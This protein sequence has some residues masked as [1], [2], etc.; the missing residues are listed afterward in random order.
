MDCA[1][2]E[3]ENTEWIEPRVRAAPPL[4]PAVR[5][6]RAIGRGA[7]RWQLNADDPRLDVPLVHAR[8]RYAVPVTVR[9]RMTR[10]HPRTCHGNAQWWRA[11]IGTP[12]DRSPPS[13]RAHQ[14]R[15]WVSAPSC[16]APGMGTGLGRVGWP[17]PGRCSR[18]AERLCRVG[19][20]QEFCTATTGFAD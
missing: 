14:Q 17:S 9:V 15:R 6:D 18:G 10:W 11:L 16:R 4:S 8:R 13:P 5:A 2:R 19:F 20:Q 7:H 3:L 1:A 12:P